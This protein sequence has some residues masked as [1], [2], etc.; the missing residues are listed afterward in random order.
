MDCYD[1]KDGIEIM[2]LITS[3]VYVDDAIAQVNPRVVMTIDVVEV[4]SC[5]ECGAPVTTDA[6]AG[7]CSE[8]CY[9]NVFEDKT[10]HGGF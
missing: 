5:P 9:L 10:P 8:H 7:L 6:F 4:P 1:A 3:G 2:N